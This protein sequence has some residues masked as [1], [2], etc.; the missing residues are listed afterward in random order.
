MVV[1]KVP[2][3]AGMRWEEGRMEMWPTG[4]PQCLH[5]LGQYGIEGGSRGSKKRAEGECVGEE[6]AVTETSAADGSKRRSE[7]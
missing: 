5:V 6:G 3:Q 7:D 1:L 2:R 4:A